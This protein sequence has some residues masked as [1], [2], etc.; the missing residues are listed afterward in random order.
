MGGGKAFPDGFHHIHGYAVS[1]LFVELGVGLERQNNVNPFIRPSLQAQAFP[2]HQTADT[3]ERLQGALVAAGGEGMS[4]FSS[5]PAAAGIFLSKRQVDAVTGVGH[6]VSLFGV[7]LDGQAYLVQAG[8]SA[9]AACLRREGTAYPFR[10]VHSFA[11]RAGADLHKRCACC[12]GE[13]KYFSPASLIKISDKVHPFSG[14][15]DSKIFAVKHL[16]FHKIPQSVQRMEDGRK[17]PAP[18]M[19]KQSGNIFKQQIRRSFCRSQPGNFKEQGTSWIVESPTVS[20]NR[21]RLAGKSAAQQFEARHSFWIGFSDIFT[22]PLSFRIEQGFIA[23]VCLFV[24]LAMAYAGK[25]SGTGEPFP[26]PANAGEQVNISYVFSYHAPF[27][28]FDESL[29][30][31]QWTSPLSLSGIQSI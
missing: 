23:L 29:K 11:L 16:P 12:S 1:G 5:N 4:D 25:P 9:E 3:L 10:G 15:G 8:F 19:V 30:H 28:G 13:R 17:C 18:V 22:K 31:N 20:S 14:L 27:E 24:D 26:E 6:F 21:K 2:W 7:L